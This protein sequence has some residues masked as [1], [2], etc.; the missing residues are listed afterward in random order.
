MVQGTPLYFRGKAVLDAVLDDLEARFS[1]LSAST[2]FVLTGTSAGGLATYLHATHVRS[3]LHTG[4]FMAAM[5]DAGFFLDHPTVDGELLFRNNMLGAYPLWNSSSGVN[6][7]CL[8]AQGG[9]ASATAWKCLFAQYTTPFLLQAGIPLFILNSLYGAID[10]GA[11]LIVTPLAHDTTHRHCAVWLDLQ[12]RL[13][14]PAQVRRRRAEGGRAVQ[15]RLFGHHRLCGS[16][17]NR[18]RVSHGV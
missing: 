1:A 16:V 15:G 17:P 6:P 2:D 12:A 5:P 8:A 11:S 3:R 14:G 18:R 10:R 4:A 7:E 13:C 9:P